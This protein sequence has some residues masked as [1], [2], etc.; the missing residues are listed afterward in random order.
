MASKFCICGDMHAAGGDDLGSAHL[1]GMPSQLQQRSCVQLHQRCI[2]K[3][4]QFHED[5]DTM[6]SATLL[7]VLP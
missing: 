4:R 3:S 2:S 1:L 6:G 7:Q 5:Q